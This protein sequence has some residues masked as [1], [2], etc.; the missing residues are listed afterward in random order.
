MTILLLA[1][2]AGLAAFHTVIGVDHYLPFVALGRARKWTLRRA[3]AVTALCGAAHVGASVVLGLGA[4]AVGLAIEELEWIDS[5][6]GGVASWLLIGFGFA[7]AVYGA[8][9]ALRTR[10]HRHAHVHADG[11]SHD[12]AHDHHGEHAHP[13]EDEHRREGAVGATTMWTLFVVFVLGP[14]E[15]LV[16]LMT[17]PAIEHAWTTVALVVAVFGAV[18]V[19][20]MLIMVALLHAG[21]SALRVSWS[22]YADMAAGLAVAASG[23]AVIA[24][25]I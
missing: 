17:A 15:T 18:T 7:Y 11:T 23:L 14:C 22:R 10:T 21:L 5:A 3:L 1:T 25:D 6:R 20:A 19:G 4:I 12:H 8:W 13:H 9:R 24:F 16:P 2:T